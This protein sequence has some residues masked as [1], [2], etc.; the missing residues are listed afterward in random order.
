MGGIGIRLNKENAFYNSAYC[1]IPKLNKSASP[2]VK[3]SKIMAFSAEI[4]KS[5]KN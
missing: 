4:K 3:G 1:S 5:K 2:N